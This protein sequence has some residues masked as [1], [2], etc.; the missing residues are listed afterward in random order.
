MIALVMLGGSEPPASECHER[1][2]C[3]DKSMGPL[4]VV[5]VALALVGVATIAYGTAAVIWHLVVG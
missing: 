4:P 5:L 2:D 3:T 1:T